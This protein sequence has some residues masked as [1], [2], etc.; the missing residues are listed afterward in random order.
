MVFDCAGPCLSTCM[1][2]LFNV[3][4]FRKWLFFSKIGISRRV[5]PKPDLFKIYVMYDLFGLFFFGAGGE[6]E[7]WYPARRPLNLFPRVELRLII[8]GL[9]RPRACVNSQVHNVCMS[10]LLR[11]VIRTDI[12][13]Y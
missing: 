13:E 9:F 1:S 7:W 10:M 8:F 2:D 4:F 3:F 11:L 6:R 5:N 12:V